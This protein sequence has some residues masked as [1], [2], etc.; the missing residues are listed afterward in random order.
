MGAIKSLQWWIR[1]EW[2]A[3]A[4]PLQVKHNLQKGSLTPAGPRRWFLIY[5]GRCRGIGEGLG[6][7]WW[8]KSE[9]FESCL[10]MTE[11]DRV[12]RQSELSRSLIRGSY[13]GS[14]T[15]SEVVQ[16]I[17]AWLQ[18]CTEQLLR[19]G[20]AQWYSLLSEPDC[21]IQIAQH[22]YCSNLSLA[23]QNISQWS[24]G[25]EWELNRTKQKHF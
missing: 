4:R 21:C 8:F 20:G 1:R 10:K 7:N 11:V 22:G 15:Q 16:F 25:L 12:E 19:A 23:L 18:P 2:L 6:V 5:R 14:R 24:D 9:R 3:W 13:Q 17:W